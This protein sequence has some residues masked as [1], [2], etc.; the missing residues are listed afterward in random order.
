MT[1]PPPKPPSGPDH[2]TKVLVHQR[3]SGRCAICGIRKMNMEIHHRRPRRAG[4]TRDPKINLPSNLVL[5]CRK[6]HDYLERGNR[7]LA[8]QNGWLL[9]ALQ[10]PAKVPFRY[11]DGLYQMNEDGSRAALAA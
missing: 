5:L 10:D 3:D 6:H 7:L 2:A 8:Y 9:N 4:G 1:R 11:Y